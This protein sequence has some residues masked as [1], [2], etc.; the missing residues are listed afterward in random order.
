MNLI[1]YLSIFYVFEG[2]ILA[3]SFWYAF[4]QFDDKD[5]KFKRAV[6]LEYLFI[7]I[8]IWPIFL[9]SAIEAGLSKMFDF[10]RKHPKFLLH[11]TAIFFSVITIVYSILTILH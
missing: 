7:I 2:L 9:P 1:L 8:F 3:L 6:T 5:W 4:T 10:Y 11:V